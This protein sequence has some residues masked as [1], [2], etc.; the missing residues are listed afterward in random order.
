[1]RQLRVANDPEIGDEILDDVC[2]TS[3]ALSTLLAEL[4]KP[5]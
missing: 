5:S 2:Y 3:A 1:M 4:L